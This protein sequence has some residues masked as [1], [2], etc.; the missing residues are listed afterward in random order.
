M[1][2]TTDVATPAS[3]D[4]APHRLVAPTPAHPPAN[5]AHHLPREPRWRA[6]N[7]PPPNARGRG[8]G[9][10][11]E[12]GVPRVPVRPRPPTRPQPLP[13]PPAPLAAN[14]R[15]TDPR[16]T[17]R[18]TT[19]TPIGAT[20]GSKAARSR[21]F[22]HGGRTPQPHTTVA[23]PRAPISGPRSDGPIPPRARVR[24]PRPPPR[25]HSAARDARARCL[26]HTQVA[27]PRVTARITPHSRLPPCPYGRVDPP[28]LERETWQTPRTECS[29]PIRYYASPHR[30]DSR[31]PSVRWSSSTSCAMRLTNADA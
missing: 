11:A 25:C 10:V 12:V 17:P 5:Q 24:S 13:G 3:Y 2:V 1:R 14:S 8:H 27:Q 7:T 30:L 19:R 16:C 31:E 4:R 26:A 15:E 6:W 29:L 21:G 23:N 28:R 22:R 20:S 9:G 18:S